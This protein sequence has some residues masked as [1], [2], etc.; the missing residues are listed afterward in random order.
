MGTYIGLT[1]Y[2]PVYFETVRGSLGEPFGSGADPLMAGTV[3]GATLSG[4]LMAK[5]THYKRVP[6]VGLLFALLGM[7]V[8]VAGWR[9]AFR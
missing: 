8:L 7:G 6:V 2:L 5:I 9:T 1:I 4:T 3:V